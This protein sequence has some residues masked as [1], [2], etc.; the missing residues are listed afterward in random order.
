MN[1]LIMEQFRVDNCGMLNNI[2]I[3]LGITQQYYVYNNNYLNPQFAIGQHYRDTCTVPQIQTIYNTNGS[4]LIQTQIQILSTQQQIFN[5]SYSIQNIL[6]NDYEENIQQN[7]LTFSGLEIIPITHECPSDLDNT[8]YWGVINVKLWIDDQEISF[9]YISICDKNFVP[10]KFDYSYLIIIICGTMIV[11]VFARF[12]RIRSFRLYIMRNENSSIQ[13]YY[14]F[15]QKQL[16]QGL[17]LSWKYFIIYLLIASLCFLLA[18]I[19]D[20][21]ETY[22]LVSISWILNVFFI[23]ECFDTKRTFRI[24]FCFGIKLGDILG[25]AFGSMPTIFYFVNYQNWIINDVIC[26]LNLGAFFKLFKITS[27][28][29]ALTLYIP[30]L[31]F[32]LCTS[33]YI[34]LANQN[35]WYKYIFDFVSNIMSLQAPLIHYTHTRRCAIL[36]FNSFFLPGLM[37]AYTNRY[38]IN[39]TI[40]VY[41]V[42]Y[43][44]GL[45]G[46]QL[47]WL[48][49]TFI[50][51]FINLPSLF[52]TLIPASSASIF[53]SYIR[54]EQNQFWAGRYYDAELLD[55]FKQKQLQQ[56]N[57]NTELVKVEDQ[58]QIQ[59]DESIFAGLKI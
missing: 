52:F 53:L 35:G 13:N 55:P 37:I 20:R 33:I 38:A 48:T 24:E 11:Y 8:N 30:F 7:N 17:Y 26:I 45:I 56:S 14:N 42:I 22:I 6:N 2:I 4:N 25:F 1:N 21:I 12:G 50:K 28:K 29:D 57:S 39:Q 10:E 36:E 47:A 18:Q 34:Y 19:E 54:N 9:Y 59:L 49:T 15:Q 27:F 40:Y 3:T 5:L 41:F 16:F 58:T 31:V 51:N 23:I 43:M 32:S 44:I 46:G